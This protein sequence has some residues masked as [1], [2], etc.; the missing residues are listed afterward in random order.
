MSNRVAPCTTDVKR[1]VTSVHSDEVTNVQL[2]RRGL[3]AARSGAATRAERYPT[4]RWHFPWAGHVV[5]GL[6]DGLTG[7]FVYEYKTT[8]SRYLAGH[9]EPVQLAQ[10]DLYGHFFG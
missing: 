9:L 10:A 4:I 5:V 3:H 1:I 8:A 2:S 7:A 6:P